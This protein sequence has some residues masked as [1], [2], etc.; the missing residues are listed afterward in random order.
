MERVVSPS[1]EELK[2]LRQPLTDGE[3]LV[4]NFFDRYLDPAWEIYIQPHLNGL[5][6]DFVL[7]NPKVGIAVFEVKDWDFNA[8]SYSIR[9]SHSGVPQLFADNGV[10]SFLIKDNPI[11]K[12]YR[13]KR[14]VFELYC[15]RLK[16]RAGYAAITAGV[17]F[18]NSNRH[19]MVSFFE[20]LLRH[21]NML[22]CPD[23]S[24]ISGK[25]SLSNGATRDVF[26]ESLR[27]FSSLITEELAADFRNWLVEPDFSKSQRQPI[28]LDT[29]QRNLV[30]S[31]TKSGYRRIRGAA[32]SGKSLVLAARAAELANQGKD[33]LVVTF[34]ITLAHYLKDIAVRWPNKTGKFRQQITWLNFHAWCRRVCE[35][36]GLEDEY[37]GL[38][39]QQEQVQSVLQVSLPNLVDKALTYSND[40][41][42]K[43]DA[44]LV[45]EGQDFLPEW[46][47]L[48][49][50]VCTSD[51]EMLLVADATQDIY[52][53]ATKWT[54]EK[55]SGA[56][57]SGPWTE[58]PIS[59]RLPQDALKQASLF[60][61][62]YLPG[63][64]TS[65][66]QRPQQNLELEPTFLR[67]IQVDEFS[68]IQTCVD[69][70][71]RFFTHS[72]FQDMAISDTTFLCGTKTQG[73]SYVKA[74]GNKGIKSVHTFAENDQEC[75]RQKVG[76]YM[77][78]ARVKATTLHSFKGWESRTLI[79][80]INGKFNRKNLAL[81]YAGL[82][83]LKRSVDGSCLTVVCAI[84]ELSEFGKGWNSFED[85]TSAPIRSH[86]LLLGNN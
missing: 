70:T 36:A 66:P 2:N 79:V 59:Y 13:Y 63:E 48:L 76:F 28:E 18:T 9:T 77:G 22:G 42:P 73:Y 50:K 11:E 39:R 34:N 83:R 64:G 27:N 68:A 58:L 67:W 20:P 19:E 44:V 47:A 24:P 6:P 7:L 61:E 54:D 26:P 40:Q 69:E 23:Y 41:I 1:R 62:R 60:A 38:W 29:T 3:W 17:I 30:M 52:D 15:P 55:M 12:I 49:R 46:W 53:T 43:Y 8:M 25:D 16:Q 57:F 72:E 74:I 56:G 14:E 32:G 33:V 71:F 78:D 81:I 65:L 82:T 10:K 4:F 45:D 37:L 5:R 21:Y 75:K 51:G 86:D 80:Y 85:K 84:P 31:R 35:S